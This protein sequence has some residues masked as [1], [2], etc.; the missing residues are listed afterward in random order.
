MKFYK[1][2]ELDGLTSRSFIYSGLPYPDTHDLGQTGA[3]VPKLM[4]DFL[5]KRYSVFADNFYNSVKLAKH[6]WKQ[7]MNICGT[8]CGDHR[9]N[10][11]Y[12]VK[13]SWQKENLCGKGTMMLLFVNGM[14]NATC[15]PFLINAV[16]KWSQ[17]PTNAGISE[18]CNRVQ[19]T[20]DGDWKTL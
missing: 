16:L 2:C 5:G 14:I 1:L 7:K 12:I 10:P 4:E 13:I 8:L 11:K 9:G 19:C 6:L 20:Q 3:I 18:T 17:Y 15:W